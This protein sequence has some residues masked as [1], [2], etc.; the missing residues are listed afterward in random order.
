MFELWAHLLDA[1]SL[2]YPQHRHTQYGPYS[3]PNC[4]T[5][6]ASY[7]P[8]TE[9][10]LT[11]CNTRPNQGGGG[12]EGVRSE[13]QA[14]PIWCKC[15]S[16]TDLKSSLVLLDSSSQSGTGIIGSL[17]GGG[18]VCGKGWK[19]MD[20]GITGDHPQCWFP[21]CCRGS[22]CRTSGC[23]LCTECSVCL[24]SARIESSKQLLYSLEVCGSVDS[25]NCCFFLSLSLSLH[26]LA[27]FFFFCFC[28][29]CLESFPRLYFCSRGGGVRDGV[30]ISTVV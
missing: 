11:I 13:H 24:N 12:G 2:A 1:W 3:L 29:R 26:H 19:W 18:K 4:N 10:L 7:Y 8:R 27:F 22:S 14:G 23:R 21:T 25:F 6:H 9:S 28:S 16:K 30:W 5:Y 15:L 20:V 17:E